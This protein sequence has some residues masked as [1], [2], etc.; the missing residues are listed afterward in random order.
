[1][2]LSLYDRLHSTV[3]VFQKA[4]GAK[5]S[6][7][8]ARQK[9]FAPAPVALSQAAMH[10]G[11]HLRLS[12]PAPSGPAARSGGTADSSDDL[13]V[14]ML[15]AAYS[16][17]MDEIVALQRRLA[18]T[19]GLLEALSVKVAEQ[20]EQATSILDAAQSSREQI[21]GAEEQLKRAARTG[22]GWKFWVAVWFTTAATGLLLLDV[23]LT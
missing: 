23:L 13:E 20:A 9:H 18:E 6:Q 2:I 15:L 7:Q 14:Q 5:L 3:S 21:E 11:E 1:M 10:V 16:S 8:L 12:G 22:S 4:E 19:A 17:D